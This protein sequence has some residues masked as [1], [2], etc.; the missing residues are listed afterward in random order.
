MGRLHV[1][2]FAAGSLM[3]CG[4]RTEKKNLTGFQAPFGANVA[5]CTR[6]DSVEDM[7]LGTRHTDEKSQASE[8]TGHKG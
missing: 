6:R 1:Q 8:K 7:P 5:G 2:G 4:P 3:C